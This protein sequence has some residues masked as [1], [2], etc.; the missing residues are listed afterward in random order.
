M[1]NLFLVLSLLLGG[2]VKVSLDN[3]V[4]QDPR[5]PEFRAMI[6]RLKEQTYNENYNPIIGPKK[7]RQKDETAFDIPLPDGSKGM[8]CDKNE[9]MSCDKNEMPLQGEEKPTGP[10]VKDLPAYRELRQSSVQGIPDWFDRVKVLECGIEDILSKD[11]IILW[12]KH[13]TLDIWLVGFD[14]NKDGRVDASI[15]IHGDS[16]YPKYYS[17]DRGFDGR[18]NIIYEDTLQDGTCNGIIV[19][20]SQPDEVNPKKQM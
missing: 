12:G 1:I 13:P 19:N 15:E 9:G 10:I 16:P 2:C 14:R 6:E 18:I 3:P 7:P 5:D 11:Q 8:K 20:D 4:V 17:F